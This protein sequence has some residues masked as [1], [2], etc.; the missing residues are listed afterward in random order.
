MFRRSGPRFADKNMRKREITMA[1]LHLPSVAEMTAEQRDV[2]DEIVGG[3]RGR[4]VGPLRAVIHSP[5]LARR[6]SRL[7]EYL[8]FST[9]LPKKLN[10]LAIIV[11]GRRWNSQ[12][13]FYIHAEAARAAGLDPAAVE[14][15]R[16]GEPPVFADDAEAEVYEFA[17]QLQQAGA[18]EPALHAAVTARWGERGVVELAGVIGY[19][20]MVSM[21]L[22]AHEIPLPDG[23]SPPLAPPPGGGLTTLPACRRAAVAQSSQTGRSR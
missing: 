18:V 11:T 5:D 10:E 14:A 2:H 23:A 20:T 6:W 17:R 12:V 21:T 7:G 8:R 9:I 19:Y 22:N 3:V 1:R 13:E 4:L 15:I 16:L